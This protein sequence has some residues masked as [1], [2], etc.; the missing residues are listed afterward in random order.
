MEELGR[1]WGSNI[2]RGR[3][4]LG[5]SQAELADA[6]GVWQSSVAKWESGENTPRDH[7][8]IKIAQA[9]KQ[10]VR[11]LFPLVKGVA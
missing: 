5:I 1:L 4:L 2:E 7:H 10:D 6:V 11:H 3:R 9:L 8:K